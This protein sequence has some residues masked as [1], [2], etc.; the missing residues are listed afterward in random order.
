MEVAVMKNVR[1]GQTELTV[2]ELCLG[3][4][5]FGST[6]PEETAFR[7]LDMYVEAGGNFIDTSNNYAHF[8]PG[9]TGDESETLLGKW[10]ASR[11]NRDQ[12]VIATK[13]GFDRHGKG[14][15]LRAE[16]I[17]YW[18]EQS[19]KKLGTD[20]IDLYYAH[21]DDPNTPYEE[22]MGAFTKLVKAGKVRVL[23]ASNYDTWRLAECQ[24]AA[25]AAGLEQYR[26]MQQCYSYL[27]ME[28]G[29]KLKYP[30]NENVDLQ[31]LRFLKDKNMPLVA[32]ACLAKGGYERPEKLPAGYIR[33]NRMNVISEMARDKG[34]SV[35]ALV[36]KWLVSAQDFTD[37]P[38]VIPLFGT[39][40]PEHLAS[41]LASTEI[42][43][44]AEEFAI[45]NDAR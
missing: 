29:V 35:N 26:A 7:L 34:V 9:G 27:F 8:V 10:L 18:C 25:K 3:A 32:Y 28:N 33:G 39:G 24:C 19:L 37:H 16:Q 21:V 14:A 13:V 11:K 40:T 23:G 5:Y 31:R 6:V 2:S 4:M 15:G 17:E 41:N 43:L 30:F 42:P 22:T 1:F 44:T 36:L 20:Y 38:Q 45:L 12:L